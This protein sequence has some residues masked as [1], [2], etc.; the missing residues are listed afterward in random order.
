MKKEASVKQKAQEL[1]KAQIGV[2]KNTKLFETYKSARK[3]M[4]PFKHGTFC[5]TADC[6]LINS[7]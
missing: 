7:Y 5:Q 4:K 3:T 2:S 1:R 6:A